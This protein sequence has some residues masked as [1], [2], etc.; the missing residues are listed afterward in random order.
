M[1]RP[2]PSDPGRIVLWTLLGLGYYIL[3]DAAFWG[4]FYVVD[5]TFRSMVPLMIGL[6]V[7]P[8]LGYLMAVQ[9]DDPVEKQDK[10]KGLLIALPLFYGLFCLA[11]IAICGGILMSG[12]KL[13]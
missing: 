2:S 11:P 5:S 1:S 8:G 7:A 12:S 4:L 3:I 13:H 6:F 10:R 9:G